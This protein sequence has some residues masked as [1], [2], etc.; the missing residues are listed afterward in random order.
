MYR[1]ISKY[2]FFAFIGITVQTMIVLFYVLKVNFI[3]DI[4]YQSR[5]VFFLSYEFF[6]CTG[7][8]RYA[9]RMHFYQY[10]EKTHKIEKKDGSGLIPNISYKIYF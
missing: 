8:C 1:E 7:K 10:N 3:T 5:S 4:R 9:H 2:I 6:R